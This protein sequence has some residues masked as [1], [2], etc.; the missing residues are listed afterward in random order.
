MSKRIVKKRSRSKKAAKVVISIVLVL[1]LVAG[2]VSLYVSNLFGRLHRQ[3]LNE[4]NLN[5]YDDPNDIMWKYHNDVKNYILFGTDAR[6]VTQQSRS[7][8]MIL[9][10][11]NFSSKTI[12]M[13]SL[14]RDLYVKVRNSYTKMSHA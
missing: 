12:K 1:A 13:V 5:I 2:G 3:E 6:M 4:T 9:L 10:S 8:V 7:D 14:Q 11:V